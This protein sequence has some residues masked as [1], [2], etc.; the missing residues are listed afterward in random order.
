MHKTMHTQARKRKRTSK[1]TE[2][3]AEPEALEDGST[4]RERT[5]KAED[6]DRVYEDLGIL[7]PSPFKIP[8]AIMRPI[9]PRDRRMS[10]HIH[11]QINA[12][13]MAA[14]E[15]PMDKLVSLKRK[16]ETG[17]DVDQAVANHGIQPVE[18]RH[19]RPETLDL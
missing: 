14:M 5:I 8:H 19:I 4:V 9:I 7:P 6:G 2:P 17:V 11:D 16:I 15:N 18:H 3:I 1:A 10:Q 13:G 12:A